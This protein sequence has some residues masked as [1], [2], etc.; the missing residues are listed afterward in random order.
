MGTKF[1]RSSDSSGSSSS[2]GR[3]VQHR[4]M[5]PVL[6]AILTRDTGL[7]RNPPKVDQPD[8]VII[9]RCLVAVTRSLTSPRSVT[10]STPIKTFFWWGGSPLQLPWNDVGSP[11]PR[12]PLT[13]T[14]HSP[15]PHNNIR[16]GGFPLSTFYKPCC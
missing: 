12:P 4:S 13:S 7:Q 3:S 1:C 6:G 16:G 11:H 8:A 5:S 9:G 15:H 14:L 2:G 10:D